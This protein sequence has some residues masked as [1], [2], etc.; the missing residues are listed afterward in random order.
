MA[1]GR[2][3]KRVKSLY[4]PRKSQS[5][6]VL[7]AA[8]MVVVVCGLGFVG[9]SI[10]NALLNYEPPN[11]AP[12]VPVENPATPPENPEP[13]PDDEINGAEQ[14]VTGD[15]PINAI[16][17]PASVLDNHTS[18]AAYIS[19]AKLNGF[20]AVVL[21]IKDSTGHLFYAS[22]FAPIQGTD[23][24]RGTLTAEQIFAAFED[25]GVR[26]VVRLNTLLD[27]LAP[28][29]MGDISY[30]F[31]AGGGRWADDFMD[32]G[33]KLWANPFLQGTRDYHLFI[34]D[35]LVNAGFS[36]I[37][38]ANMLFPQ[39]RNS[40]RDILGARFTAPSTRYEGLVGFVKALENSGADFYL[41]M[42]V[43]DVLENT[44]TAE[45][46]RGGQELGGFE[47][48]LV[49]NRDDFSVEH[50]TSNNT[51]AIVSAMYGRAA[52]QFGDFGITPLLSREG[53]TD[54]EIA[55]ILGVFGE[56]G[57]EDFIIR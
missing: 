53:L 11:N 37:I 33:G 32:R 55:D 31:E 52:N 13:E 29:I 56:L 15:S 16:L 47:L 14:I 1:R 7:E 18:L 48:L 5:R 49:Y 42:T 2:K 24:I 44:A 20:N 34:T 41:E 38:L 3:V 17:A 36:D 30:V 6:K 25:T 10:G 57:F 51:G 35:E 28:A 39:F 4:K 46:L 21:E 23:I 43:A 40:D 45:I 22:E 19:Q 26:P 12:A 54:R 9:W 50:D 27:R 8:V